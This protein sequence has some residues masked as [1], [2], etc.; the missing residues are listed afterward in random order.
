M[1]I[2]LNFPRDACI[3][4]SL[5]AILVIQEQ[6]VFGLPVILKVAN[7]CLSVKYSFLIP[8]YVYFDSVADFFFVFLLRKKLKY[9]SH[10]NILIK[11]TVSGENS[12]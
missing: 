8:E 6:A 7:H 11:N 9:N 12:V 2:G 10:L 4:N 5:P 1:I 3:S